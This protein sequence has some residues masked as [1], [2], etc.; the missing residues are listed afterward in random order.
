MITTITFYFFTSFFCIAGTGAATKHTS[1]LVGIFK[2]K[3]E[4]KK[5]LKTNNNNIDTIKITNFRN[6]YIKE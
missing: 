6:K 5:E 3:R 1:D 2:N 4:F